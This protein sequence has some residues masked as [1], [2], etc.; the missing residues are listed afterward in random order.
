MRVSGY[1]GTSTPFGLNLVRVGP[2]LKLRVRLGF[3]LGFGPNQKNVAAPAIK[4]I[5]KVTLA[6]C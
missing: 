2:R 3:C 4:R 6:A 1:R 5:I